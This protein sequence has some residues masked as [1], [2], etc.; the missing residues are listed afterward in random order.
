MKYTT[1][2]SSGIVVSRFCLGTMLFGGTGSA[3]V[4]AKGAH[5][6]VDAF[7]DGG[8]T[9]FDSANVYT[10]GQAEEILG[11]ALKGRRDAHVVATKGGA[12]LGGQPRH[13]RAGLTRTAV[14]SSIDDSLRRLGT[15]YIDIWYLHGPDRLTPIE[16]TWAAVDIA[17]RAG[18]IRAV[19]FSNLPAWAAAE[20]VAC[21][22]VP[23]AAAQ[24]QYS[25]VCRDIE[26][27]FLD[28]LQRHG[29]A[30]HAWGPLGQGFLT[31]K[32][33]PNE[34]PAE[35]RIAGAAESHEEHWSR[36][37]NDRNWATLAATREVAERR[38]ATPGQVAVAWVLSRPAL[39]AGVVGARTERQLAETLGAL[40]THLEKADLE[41]L[42]EA[43][44]PPRRYPFR[45]VD[46]YFDRRP[47]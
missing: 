22:P 8:G 35:G 30:L 33:R 7:I 20:A 15:D 28:G 27:D 39:A 6:I 46:A 38:G 11:A 42:D 24:Y 47:G 37:D 29:I 45:V 12:Q 9:Y 5:R 18:K 43:S 41:L 34:K 17:V 13:P 26:D 3:E 40:S 16:E 25:L 10:D 31:G 23:V 2:G 44:K 36:R 1:L 32:Y 19:G 21:A 4:D 14:L